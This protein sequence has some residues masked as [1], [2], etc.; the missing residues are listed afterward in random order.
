MRK[1]AA[2]L[3]ILILFFYASTAQAMTGNNLRVI[4]KEHDQI[5]WNG[6]TCVGYI[7]DVIETAKFYQLVMG[8]KSMFC[9]P[10]DTDHGGSIKKVIRYLEIMDKQG[11]MNANIAINHALA[12][13][14][15]CK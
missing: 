4:C 5:N 2:S 3:L 6:G 11:K 13:A 10:L 1:N 14:Y 12:E 15:P 9:R 8:K 7:T